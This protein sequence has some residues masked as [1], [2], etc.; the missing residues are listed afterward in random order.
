[1]SDLKRSWPAVSYNNEW[2]TLAAI[3][4]QTKPQAHSPTI[5]VAQFGPL[6]TWFLIKSLYL[7]L[8]VVEE[9]ENDIEEDQHVWWWRLLVDSKNKLGHLKAAGEWLYIF[10]YYM[11]HHRAKL[12]R[13]KMMQFTS[14]L[15]LRL[16]LSDIL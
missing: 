3:P 16:S 4:T 2:N 10:F 8:P 7:S 5:A 11:L 13:N 1:M 9:K 12:N 6:D 14:F 15:P